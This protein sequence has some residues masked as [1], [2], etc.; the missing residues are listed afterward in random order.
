MYGSKRDV[1]LTSGRARML[2]NLAG[3]E[4]VTRKKSVSVDAAVAV[5]LMKASMSAKRSI[6]GVSEVGRCRG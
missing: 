4:V 3:D 6:L 2:L 1:A 5:R